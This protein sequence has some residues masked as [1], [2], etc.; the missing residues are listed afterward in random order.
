MNH[1]QTIK[2]AEIDRAH[3]SVAGVIDGHLWPL[4]R[5]SHLVDAPTTAGAQNY[6]NGQVWDDVGQ[7]L[8]AA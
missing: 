8:A 4:E 1:P 5:K 3:V 6:H 7:L 2:I